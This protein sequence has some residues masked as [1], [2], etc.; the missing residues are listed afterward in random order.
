MIIGGYAVAFHGYPR[1][2]KDIDI[3]FLNTDDNIEKLQN[4]LIRFG[5]PKKTIPAK[6]FKKKG[7]IIQ[8][9]IS[10]MR[11]DLLN[12]IPGITFEEAEKHMARGPFGDVEVNFIGITD[13]IKNKIASGRPQDK[14][15]AKILKRGKKQ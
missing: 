9:G 6:L 3:L 1:F 2:T 14:V 4:S 7:D 12:K 8:F 11:I 13:L 10:P 15:D 5:F